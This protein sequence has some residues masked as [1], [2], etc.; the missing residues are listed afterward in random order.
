MESLLAAIR[1]ACSASTWSRGVELARSDAVMLQERGKSELEFRVA[2]KGGMVAPIVTLFP[3]DDEW[4]CECNFP[5]DACPH[6][7]AAAIAWQQDQAGGKPLTQ[8][9]APKA[10]GRIAYR[11]ETR[12]ESLALRRVIV[13]EGGEWAFDGTLAMVAQGKLRGPKFVAAPADLRFEKHVG[14]FMAQVLPKAGLARLFETLSDATDVTLDGTA[15]RLGPPSSGLRVLVRGEGDRVFAQ[16]ERDP[17]VT[18]VFKNGAIRRGDRLHPVGGHGLPEG[19]FNELRRG[20][21]FDAEGMATL[22]GDLVPRW[23][24]TLPIENVSESVPQARALKPRIAISTARDGDALSLL[25]TVVYGDPAVARVDGDR[26]TSLREG[27]VPL[28]NLRL[29]KILVERMREE[30]GLEPGVRRSLSPG[31]A[32]AW[33]QRFL[34]GEG[35]AVEGRAHHDFVLRGE[36]VPRLGEG[37]REGELAFELELDDGDAGG[38]GGGPRGRA[39]P[40]AVVAAW[41][42]GEELVPLVDGGFARLPLEFLARHGER[43]AALLRAREA[44]RDDALPTWATADLAALCEALERPAPPQWQHLRGL[45][46]GFEGLGEPVLPADVT[47]SLRDYQRRG[48]AWLSFLQDAKMGGLLADDMGLGKTLQ[49]LCAIRGRTL[50]VAPTSVLPN[51]AAE[52]ARFRPALRVCS[53]HGP[54]RELGRDAD[55]TLTSFALLRLDRE[56]LTRQSWDTVVIDEAQAI[57]NPDSQVARAAFELQA[58]V[59]F[60]LTGTP[61][62]NRLEDLWSQFHFANPGLLGGRSEFL[63]RYARPIGS[64]DASATAALRERIRPFV[65]R[66][67]KREVA[68]ELPP[69]TDLVLHC[70]L[71]DEERAVYDAVRAATREDIAARLGAGGEVMAMLEALLRLRQAACDSAL[72]PGQR[73]DGPPSSKLERLLDTLATLREAG[74]KA[75]VFSQWTSLLDRVEPLLAEQ[76]VPYLRLDGSTSDRGAV[77]ERF[78]AD[79]G[80]PVLLISLRAGGTGLNLT[81]ADHVFLLDPWW[82]PAVEDQAADRAHRIGQDKPVFVHRLVARNTVEE[83][84]LALQLRKRELAAAAL[85]GGTPATAITRD[86]LL[87]LLD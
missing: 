17:E 63:E 72:V 18:M 60:A 30:L 16:L 12:G 58:R 61:V 68:R 84:I 65:L 56:L 20:K 2:T 33:N 44:A 29:E 6:V 28:R 85:E 69:R 21:W 4:S 14:T 38:S 11:F 53:Y 74:S 70:E 42:R 5:E 8:A 22:A 1:K 19:E 73:S 76:G 9:D 27:D 55:V 82:N 35:Y 66:R 24:R 80:P 83:G 54:G 78:Q 59:R 41:R 77:V 39:E 87:A 71:R 57:K 15:V 64:G 26:L 32:V 23:K 36:V 81:A 10:P 43:V 75:L 50:V 51:W 25:G 40:G 45:F 86:E 34:G 3:D 48:V 67:L 46:E 13:H 62:E 31:E 37:P 7:A 79:D 49:T 52:I 47:A